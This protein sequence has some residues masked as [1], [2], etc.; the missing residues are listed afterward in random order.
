M[1][2]DELTF[3]SIE[4]LAPLLRQKKVSPVEL[5]GTLL[6]RIEQLNPKLNAYLT[7]TAEQ[8]LVQARQAETEI[9]APRGRARYRGPLHGIPIALKDNIWTRGILT[10]AGSKILA[11][12]VPEEDATVVSLL[13]KAGAILLGKTNLHEFAYGVTTNNPHYGPTRNPWNTER[14]AGG[15]S[16]GSAAAIASGMCVASVGTDTGGSIRIPAALCGIVGLKP[17]FGRVSCH[18]VIPLCKSLDHVGAL[19]RTV[20][21]AAIMLRAIAGPDQRDDTTLPAPIPDYVRGLR[22]PP[23]PPGG[24]PKKQKA[25]LRLGLPREYFWEKLDDEVHRSVEAAA[26]V[27]EHLGATIEEI[28]LPHLSES[29]EPNTQI[30]LAE[31]RAFHQSA[32]WFPA[33]AADYGEDVRKRLEMGGEVRAIDYLRGGAVRRQVRADFEAVFARVDA[34]FAP[35]APIA[36]PPI[37]ANVVKIGREEETVR[38]ALLR[39]NRTAN[40]VGLPALSLPCGFTKDTLPVGL[41]LIGPMFGEANLL[42]IAYAYEQATDWH[43]RYPPGL[44]CTAPD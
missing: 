41:Q 37:G 26:R 30:A 31:A 22:R 25:P 44:S 8:A 33:R 9:C 34:I 11:D 5:V 23:F 20:A 12:F 19:A 27:F 10:T 24:A 6:R 28:P 1:S 17:S 3:A 38:S 29:V 43:R 21:D 42:R 40:F 32:G 15:S 16:G 14:I 13:R 18:G 36:A 4:Q 2:P 7:V 39:L 35:T